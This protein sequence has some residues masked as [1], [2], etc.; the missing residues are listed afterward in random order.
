MS[1]QFNQP[2]GGNS[3][4]R[5]A[6]PATMFRLPS[7]S[8]A[9]G[10]DIAI[11]GVPLDIGTSNRAGTRFGPRQIRSESVLVRPYGMA[12]RAAPFDSFQVADIGDVPLNT[13][14]LEKSIAIIEQFYDAVVATG[15]KP[16]SLG[17]DHTIALPILRA[18]AKRHGK[19]ALVHVDAHADINDTMFG[20]KVAHGTIFRRAL[21]EGLVDGHKMTQIG[22]R[23]TGYSAGDFDWSREQGATV[24]QAEDCWYRSLAPVMDEVRQRIGPDTPTYLS[25][26]IDGLDPSVAPGTGTPEPAGLTAAQGLE[27]IRGV[28]GTDL[29]GADL[30]EV[31]PPY[32]TTGNT[33]LLAANLAFEML[34]SFPGC[35]RR[36]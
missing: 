31:S 25:F 8:D 12:T 27:I 13:F 7:Q 11:V 9:T 21:E 14:N 24:I 17:G 23:A 1:D 4:P 35:K 30:V 22:L 2:L 36:D 16:L 33:S 3:M 15:A 19:M 28:F 26:D 6:G 5:F 10:L 32:D 29:I 34:C 20:E 18:L